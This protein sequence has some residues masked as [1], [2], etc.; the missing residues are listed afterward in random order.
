M[1]YKV[2]YLV[3]VTANNNNKFYKMIP[4][5]NTV[6]IQYGRLGSANFQTRS[7]PI[8]QFDKKYN[9]KI[10]KGYKDHTELIEETVE[11]SKSGNN[12]EYKPISDEAVK[13]IVERLMQMARDTIDANY[14]ISSEAV[15]MKMVDKAQQIL[16]YLS[17]VTDAK[18]FNESLIDLFEVLPRKM[19]YVP[20]YLA[21]DSNNFSEIISREQGLLDVMR[22]QVKTDNTK[23]D[24][25]ETS[26]EKSQ[27][28]I[29]EDLNLSIR[30]VTADEEKHIKSSL[31]SLSGKYIRAWRVVND[32]TQNK[33]DNYLHEIGNDKEIKELWHGSRNENWWSIFKTGLVL[34]PTN[35]VITGKMFGYGLYFAPV[36]A[37]SMGYTSISGSRWANGNSSSGFLAIYDVIYGDPYLIDKDYYSYNGLNKIDYNDLQKRK[38]GAHCLHALKNAGLREE[39]IIVYKEEQCTIKYLVEIKG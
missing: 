33:F 31:R 20:D 3:M 9:E 1:S 22:G 15:T 24:I 17:K 8:S 37:K 26:V 13:T 32:E 4:K 28:T 21:V 35:A 27:L 29:L 6:E 12:T 19:N 18:K 38:S 5:G 25:N 2:K 30:E 36:A 14:K 39:E 7:Y 11:L 16:N 23:S 34:R 10:R